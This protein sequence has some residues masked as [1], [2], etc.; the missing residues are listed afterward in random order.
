MKSDLDRFLDRLKKEVAE[1]R[2]E[3]KRCTKR[4][5]LRAARALLREVL[6]KLS[7]IQEGTLEHPE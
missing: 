2:R 1:A 6:G 3:V 5:D 7:R 4:G